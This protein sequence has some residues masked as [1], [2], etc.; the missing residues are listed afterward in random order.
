MKS[1]RCNDEAEDTMK[2]CRQSFIMQGEDCTIY[3]PYSVIN[4]ALKNIKQKL[5]IKRNWQIPIVTHLYQQLKQF[6]V[7]K[8]KM[9]N[10]YFN[11]ETICKTNHNL[12]LNYIYR[13]LHQR[14]SEYIFL[15]LYLKYLPRSAMVYSYVRPQQISHFI[16]T[17]KG[18]NSHFNLEEE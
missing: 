15:S 7:K 6:Q 10:K 2:S 13:I 11:I 5:K 1:R 8:E 4:I 3:N 16:G 18:Q 14:V 17:M 12:D 9:K